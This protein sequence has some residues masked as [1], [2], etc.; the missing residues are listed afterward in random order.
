MAFKLSSQELKTR[1][2]LLETLK[3]LQEDVNSAITE[4]N[5]KLEDVQEFVDSVKDRLQNEFD[6]KSETWQ[7]GDKGSEAQNFISEFENIE[8]IEL[9]VDSTCVDNFENLPTEPQ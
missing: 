9:E 3:S 1:E 4:F 7:E 2:E 5:S 6:E 8:L